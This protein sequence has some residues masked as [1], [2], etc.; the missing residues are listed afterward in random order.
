MTNC[1]CDLQNA[2]ATY[3]FLEHIQTREGE[4]VTI[5]LFGKVDQ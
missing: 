4:K 1:L 5:W 3:I 2:I